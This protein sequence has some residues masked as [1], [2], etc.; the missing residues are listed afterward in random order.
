MA[1]ILKNRHSI[2]A[3]NAGFGHAFSMLRPPPAPAAALALFVCFLLPPPPLV[4]ESPPT[5]LAVVHHEA[6]RTVAVTVEGQVF[7]KLRYNT[8][9][10]P[11][12]WPLHGPG[13][14]RMT[15]DWPMKPDTPGDDQDHPHHKSVWFTHGDVN[16]VDFWS[17]SEKAGRVVT[18]AVPR[19]EIDPDGRALIELKNEW[20]APDG[21]VICTDAT[22]IRCSLEGNARLIDYTI[23]VAATHGRVT[24]GDTKE[25]TMA[26]RTRPELNVD[27]KNPLAAG[28]ARNREGLIGKALWGVKSAWVDYQAPV[29]GTIAGLALFDHPSNLRHPTTWH[30]RDYG[31]IA[32]N[33]FGLHDFSKNQ[34]KGAGTHVIPEGQTTTWRYGIHLYQGL[35]KATTIDASWAAWAGR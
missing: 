31:L 7:T 26:V 35:T 20:R 10:K 22:V 5:T 18:T 13:G 33:P 25:G 9:A 23:T 17:E 11:I 6:D 8:F 3:A 2:L 4:A 16:G 27:R 19:A 28:S 34:P 15:R 14:V 29:A 21:R 30:A 12:L 24:F 32:A 1:E